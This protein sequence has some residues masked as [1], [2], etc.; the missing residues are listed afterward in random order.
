MF[1][2]TRKKKIIIGLSSFLIVILGIA[3]SYAWFHP[4]SSAVVHQVQPASTPTFRP[5]VGDVNDPEDDDPDITVQ[6]QPIPGFQFQRGGY[7]L[8]GRVIDALS[9][10]PLFAAVVWIDLPVQQGKPTSMALH[11]ITDAMGSYQFMHI[12][13]GTYTVVA[14]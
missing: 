12:A 6:Q 14:S 10:Q 13:L 9:G 8:S 7:E 4:R 1:A 3:A 2:K 11:T 5:V